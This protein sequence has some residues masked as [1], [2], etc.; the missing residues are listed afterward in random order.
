MKRALTFQSFTDTGFR[1]YIEFCYPG[2][3]QHPYNLN[4]S[5][6][7]Q[8]MLISTDHHKLK[9]YSTIA[10]MKLQTKRFKPRLECKRMNLCKF[11][12]IEN[13]YR[14]LSFIESASA[15]AQKYLIVL[16]NCTECSSFHLVKSFY[17]W[18]KFS[19]TNC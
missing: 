16:I 1:I 14:R 18:L 19:H 12:T 4:A 2:I 3:Y 15:L 10:R 6:K 13:Y 9:L 8:F 11:C 17:E 5:R 7:M